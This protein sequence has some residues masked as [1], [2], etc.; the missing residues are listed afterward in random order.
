MIDRVAVVAGARTPFAKLN[1]ELAEFTA[2]DLSVHAV[3]GLMDRYGIEPAEVDQLVWGIVGVDPRTPHLAREVAFSTRLAVETRSVTVTDNCITSLTAV[4]QVVDA[5]GQGRAKA[6]IA[7][8]W[9][10]SRTRPSCCPG[11]GRVGWW[12]SAALAGGGIVWRRSQ[13]SD[14]V[15]SLP[16]SPRS[17]NRRPGCRWANTP[18]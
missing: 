6:A 8:G 4:E 18:N 10:P 5:I 13:R 15:T 12:L 3:D 7:G 14:R 17:K 1:G 9:N 2:L 11:V 16:S